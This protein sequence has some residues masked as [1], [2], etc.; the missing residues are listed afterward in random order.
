MKTLVYKK[1]H[2]NGSGLTGGKPVPGSIGSSKGKII[3]SGLR[4]A[5]IRESGLVSRRRIN[6]II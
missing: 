1:K 4:G 2:N 5:R 3:E 6:R